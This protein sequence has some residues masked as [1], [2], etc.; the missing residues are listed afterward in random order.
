M[1]TWRRSV[2]H[3]T[4]LVPLT[5]QS[6]VRTVTCR[7]RLTGSGAPPDQHCSW[8]GVTQKSVVFSTQLQWLCGV[9]GDINTPNQHIEDTRATPNIHTT[10]ATTPTHSKPPSAKSKWSEL[11]RLSALLECS[12]SE[13]LISSCA[14]ALRF[15]SSSQPYSQVVKL[16]KRLYFVGWRS[17]QDLVSPEKRRTLD[18]SN[19]LREREMVKRDLY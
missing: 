3:W 7:D 5:G 15:L 11:E 6:F 4:G 17:L 18:I 12:W 9:V 13:L 16:S 2:A 8:T 19:R 1:M 14:L 10:S